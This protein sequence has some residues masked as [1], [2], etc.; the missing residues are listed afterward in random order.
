MAHEQISQE[1][2]QYIDTRQNCHSVCL[3]SIDHFSE[4]GGEQAFANHI[5]LLQDCVRICQTSADFMLRKGDYPPKIHGVYAD[6]YQSCAA[7]CEKIATG[8]AT[9]VMQ[10]CADACRQCAE[11]CRRMSQDTPSMST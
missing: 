9:D 5:K 8:D 10:R 3:Q 2:Q 4:M 7:E 11:S 1:M 6:I